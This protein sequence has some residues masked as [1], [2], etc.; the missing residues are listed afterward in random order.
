MLSPKPPEKSSRYSFWER[1]MVDQSIAAPPENRGCFL[2]GRVW[3]IDVRLHSDQRGALLPFDFA[4]LPFQPKRLFLVTDVPQGVQRGCHGHRSA[5]QLLAC[6]KGRVQVELRDRTRRELVTLE[7]GGQA[8][9]LE[10][11]V[12][13]AQT[14]ETPESVLLVLASTPYDPS[15]YFHDWRDA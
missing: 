2:G 6:A 14:Y 15:D 9:L 1:E 4:D 11:N 5:R 12:W 7:P 8:L 10:P 3:F 13:A